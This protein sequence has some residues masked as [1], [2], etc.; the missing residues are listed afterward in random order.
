MDVDYNP[1]G[2]E[3]VTSHFCRSRFTRGSSIIMMIIA[4]RY[5]I[6]RGCKV[7]TPLMGIMLLVQPIST[8]VEISSSEEH[9]TIK[10]LIKASLGNDN[11]MWSKLD[12]CLRGL[13]LEAALLYVQTSLKDVRL[14]S[15]ISQAFAVA[16]KTT[17]RKDK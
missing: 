16:T 10:Q 6:L 1:T 2:W 11:S 4:G 17:T 9:E 5:T 8:D 13:E 14:L 3:F 12:L 15:S 7:W